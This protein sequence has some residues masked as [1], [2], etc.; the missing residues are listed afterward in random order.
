MQKVML[1]STVRDQRGKGPARQLRMKGQVPAVLYS[2]GNSS[3][4]ALNPKEID[5]MLQTPSGENSLITLQ[6]GEE[7]SQNS[8]LAILKALQR[9]PIRGQIL[10]VDLLE[11]SINDPLTMRIPVEVFGVSVGVKNS[12]GVLQNNLRELEIRCL[13][14]LIP[15]TIRVDIS[16]LKLGDALHVKDIAMAE[17]IEMIADPDGVVVS[18]VAPMSEAQLQAMLTTVPKDAKGPEVTGEKAKEEEGKA[19]AKGASAAKG[20]GAKE[21]PKAKGKEGAKK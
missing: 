9:D 4:Y 6:S 21:E 1:N 15:D 16:L 11:I 5:K 12:G 13:P 8:R 19:D 20:K 10:H 3:L 17:G 18:V 14:S 7:G 2:K